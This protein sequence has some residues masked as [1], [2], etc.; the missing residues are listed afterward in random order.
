MHAAVIEFYSLADAVGA[1]SEDHHLLTVAGRYFI[2]AVISGVVVGG[3][4]DAAYRHG[5]PGLFHTQ[6]EAFPPHFLFRYSEQLGK[7]A[8]GKAVLLCLNQ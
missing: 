7:I 3:I 4:L 1:S 8:V 2:L 6:G 5:V